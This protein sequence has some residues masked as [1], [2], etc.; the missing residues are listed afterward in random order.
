MR[1]ARAP[2]P[3]EIAATRVVALTLGEA[4]AKARVGPPIDDDA[5][6]ALPVWSGILPIAQRFG[7]PIAE[8]PGIVPA[9]EYVQ[10]CGR[11]G[12]T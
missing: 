11:F 3:R 5:D 12:E 10:R 4:S 7:P 2:S 6:L 9:P 8:G 1:D